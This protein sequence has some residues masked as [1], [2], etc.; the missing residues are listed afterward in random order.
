MQ[1]NIYLVKINF[2]KFIEVVLFGEDVVIVKGKCL[3]VWIVFI[4]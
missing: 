4:Y 2:L 3:M 1:F